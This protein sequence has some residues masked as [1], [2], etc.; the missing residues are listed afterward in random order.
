MNN[1]LRIEDKNPVVQTCDQ[2]VFWSLQVFPV[3][4]ALGNVQTSRREGQ[5]SAALGDKGMKT[6]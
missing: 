2:V 4:A 6:S 5:E 3:Q 1:V